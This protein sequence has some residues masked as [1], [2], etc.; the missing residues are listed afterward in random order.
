[1]T[2]G[3]WKAADGGVCVVLVNWTDTAADWSGV[4]DTDG[5]GL[6]SP[7]SLA[8]YSVHATRL[9]ASG[10]ASGTTLF[11]P[12]T[13]R[14]E[15]RSIAA[16]TVA[17][18]TLI[19][20]GGMVNLV[21]GTTFNTWVTAGGL[22][23]LIEQAT[24]TNIDRGSMRPSEASVATLSTTPPPSPMDRELWQ[25]SPSNALASY[26]SAG[27]AFR[28]AVPM[29]RAY[30]LDGTA[31]VVAGDALIAT[32][33]ATLSELKLVKSATGFPNSV[34]VGIATAACAVGSKSVC[35][36]A[37]PVKCNTTGTIVAGQAVKLSS[38]AGLLQNA[39]SPGSGFGSLVIG[40]CITDA[41]GGTAWINLAR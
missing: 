11:D 23:A 34:V 39:G 41:T 19:Q 16:F 22:H 8:A 36:I 3:V 9:N 24:I 28:G 2:S 31:A 25:T 7:G 10:A 27:T 21:K 17:A 35:V 15:V 37:G 20:G 13:G 1:M 5:A 14:L 32:G 26:D 40:R 12:V 6:G 38:T 18:V 4:V 30:T 33:S 29:V